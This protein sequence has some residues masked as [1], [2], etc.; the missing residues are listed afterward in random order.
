MSLLN[1]PAMAQDPASPAARPL[2]A[3]PTAVTPSPSP[4]VDNVLEAAKA[5]AKKSGKRVALP[6]RYSEHMKV[7]ANTDGKTLHAELHTAP[8]HLEV[9]G[10][11]GEKTWRAIDTTIVKQADGSYTSTFVKTPLKFGGK[12]TT[13]VVTADG[14]KGRAVVGWGRELPEPKVDGDTITY[15]DAVAE[16]ADLVVR[17]LADGFTQEVVLRER[18]AET[19]T[20]TLP[21]TLPK[22]MAYGTAADGKTPQLKSAQGAA[23]SAPLTVQAVDAIAAESFG[24]GQA[25]A[26]PVAVQKT[27]AGTSLRFTA[28]QTLLSRTDVTYPVTVAMQSVF[29][30]AGLAG[31]TFVAKNA[32]GTNYSNGYLRVGTTASNADVARVY[33]KFN[34]WDTDLDYATIIDANYMVWNY[35]SGG[36]G[37]AG[38][39]CGNIGS[40][41]VTRRVTSSMDVNTMTWN[42]GQPSYTTNGQVGIQYGYSEPPICS[43]GGELVYSIEDIVREWVNGTPDHGLVMMA[44][45]ES[46]VTNWRQYRSQETGTHDRHMPDHEPILFIEYTPAPRASIVSSTLNKLAAPPTTYEAAVALKDFQSAVDETGP[47]TESFTSATQGARGPNDDIEAYKLGT[48]EIGEADGM[49]PGGEDFEPPSV[50]G[51]NPESDST[52]VPVGTTVAVTYSEDVVGAQITLRATDGTPVAGETSI[53]GTGTVVTFTPAL[54]LTEGATYSATA[55][56]AQDVWDNVADDHTWFFTTAGEDTTPPA[57]VVKNPDAGTTDAA[58][59]TTITATFNEPVT[60]AQIAL[61]DADDEAVAGEVSVVGT[62][63]TFIPADPLTPDT[64]Y[65]VDVTGAEDG[66]GNVMT[67]VTWTFTTSEVTVPTDTTPPSVVG[68]TPSSGATGV[69]VGTTVTATFSEPVSSALLVLKGAGGAAVAG[70]TAM[71]GAVTTLTFTANQPL[72]AGVLHTVEVSGASDAAG[73]IMSPT[74]WTFTTAAPPPAQ[75]VNPN[76]FFETA[77]VPWTSYYSVDV[78]SRSTVRAH[79]GVGSARFVPELETWGYALQQF[80]ISGG[81]SYQLSGW[82]YPSV[83]DPFEYG[84]DYGVEWFDAAGEEISEDNLTGTPAVGQ[85]Q[86]V[87]GIVTAPA[88]TAS[89]LV[90]VGVGTTLF[91]DELTLTPVTGTAATQALRQQS[92]EPPRRGDVASLDDRDHAQVTTKERAPAQRAAALATAAGFNYNHASLEDCITAHNATGQQPG[93]GKPASASLLVR[94]YST[95]WSS[96]YYV[97]DWI[98]AGSRGKWVKKPLKNGGKADALEFRATW[99]INTYLGT[100]DGAHVVGG[101]GYRPQDISV[102]TRIGQITAYDD[103]WATNEENDRVLELAVTPS[104]S[105]GSRCTATAGTDI[106]RDDTIARWKADGDD[107]FRFL[108][109]DTDNDAIDYCTLRPTLLDVHGEWAPQPIRL[110]NQI[111]YDQRSGQATGRWLGG[112]DP[113]DND[114]QELPYIPHV[115]CNWLNLSEATAGAA[116]LMAAPDEPSGNHGGC[117]HPLAKR[118]FTMKESRDTDFTEVIDHIKDARNQATN[119]LTFPPLRDGA[120]YNVLH[121]PVIGPFGNEKPKGPMSGDWRSHANSKEGQPFVKVSRKEANKSRAI[122]YVSE[123]TAPGSKGLF[124]VDGKTYFGS[125]CRYYWEDEY[126]KTPPPKDRNFNCDEFPWASTSQ[127]ALNANGHYSIKGI[128]GEQNQNHGR[129]LGAWYTKMQVLDGDRFWYEIIP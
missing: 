119:K 118:I 40:G 22:G 10:A 33:V 94:P 25:L 24:G 113:S 9:D 66:A 45:S 21:V 121:P 31:D 95:C 125:W 29:V 86:Q 53:D 100:A 68:G 38:A 96:W 97:T 88:G 7:W 109:G 61:R 63:V 116:R 48:D 13:T 51:V 110:W 34:V 28:D 65:T 123:Y 129:K 57:V 103:N 64:A 104:G 23:E 82:F 106:D 52:D 80:P 43:G 2:T 62:A 111:A 37:S 5:Q 84:F 126:A 12:G 42:S 79:Q 81:G 41:I 1:A 71:D 27:A 8:I 122:F 128:S 76:P 98:W 46:A 78:L 74:T 87:S 99:V 115:R 60:D 120:I 90:Y 101:G 72:A 102:W 93:D 39:N 18:P 55:S 70:T 56:G 36:T 44:P 127:G 58:V 105:P 108:S 91:M 19:L 49:N 67:P 112:G 32:P 73:N 30:G 20:W 114:P 4:M 14:A 6:S 75:P 17:A 54:P 35:K 92:P 83:A 26:V 47:V 16:G 50:I 85:W 124:T 69:A 117:I 3:D 107:Y 77:I 59:D 15:P 11:D 89:A